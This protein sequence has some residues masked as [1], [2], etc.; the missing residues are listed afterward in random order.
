MEQDNDNFQSKAINYTSSWAHS[1]YPVYSGLN[2]TT[3][4]PS[5]Q[6]IS[7]QMQGSARLYSSRPQAIRRKLFHG[8]KPTTTK[9]P[10]FL[11]FAMQS[12]SALSTA[13]K[14]SIGITHINNNPKTRSETH[15]MAKSITLV[16]NDFAHCRLRK[17]K[18]TK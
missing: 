1:Y 13:T 6:Q 11:Q 7:M 14:T 16:W 9:F 2:S 5:T 8:N 17:Q 4:H 12:S 3:I 15:S 10:K 18:E